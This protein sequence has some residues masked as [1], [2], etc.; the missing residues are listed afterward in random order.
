MSLVL[1]AETWLAILALGAVNER[2]RLV[3]EAVQTI[4]VL[5]D[6]GVVLR[7]ELPA[8]FRGIDGRVVGHDERLQMKLGA[9]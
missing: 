5:V 7:D 1:L 6:E 2:R 3:V 9:R 4:G 8:H